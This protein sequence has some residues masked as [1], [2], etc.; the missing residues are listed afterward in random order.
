M[1]NVTAS[2][3]SEGSRPGIVAPSNKVVVALPFGRVEIGHDSQELHELAQLVAE[4]A[5]VI[6]R[7]I[8][9]PDETHL[10]E[11]ARALAGRLG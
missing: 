1:S 5:D 4:L 11:R 3:T 10:S 6:A 7:Q 2:R 8:P 9:G